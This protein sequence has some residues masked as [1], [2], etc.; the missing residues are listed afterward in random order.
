[1]PVKREK[2]PEPDI[3]NNDAWGFLMELQLDHLVWFV[4][5]PEDAINPFGKI[6]IHVVPGGRHE[7]W[8]TSNSLAYFG[9]SY[10]E[11]LGIENDELAAKITENLLV[12]Q[13]VEEMPEHPGPARVALRTANMKKVVN[14]LKHQGVSFYGPFPGSRRTT[15]GKRIE[16]S[17]L[18]PEIQNTDG[19]HLPFLIEW[20]QN[21]RERAEDLQ[22]QGMIQPQHP[23]LQGVGFVVKDLDII[24]QWA[25]I[26]GLD[27]G[28]SQV[29]RRWNARCRTLRLNGGQELIFYY[30]LGDG[31]AAK[32]LETRGERP[33]L[34]CFQGN[35]NSAGDRV[36]MNGWLRFTSKMDSLFF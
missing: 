32:V 5:R 19:L 24:D 29:D 14:H 18:F 25:A 12:R 23:I 31:M 35:Q 30:P 22:K 21:D 8:G 28:E 6:G 1:M 7:N 26:F 9:L 13:I 17:L 11:F 16:W 36:I 3:E 33:F 10:I 20:K 4:D 15:A 34:V 2:Q 27:K